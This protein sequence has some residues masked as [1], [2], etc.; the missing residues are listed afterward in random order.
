MAYDPR[1]TP[2]PSGWV[3]SR[4]PHPKGIAFGAMMP[5]S[6]KQLL[7]L[8]EPWLRWTDLQKLPGTSLVHKYI[9]SAGKRRHVGIPQRL[10]QSQSLCSNFIENKSE[11]MHP[12][13][14][15]HG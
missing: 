13:I 3:P 1:S 15:S 8:V 6:F 10:K 2:V 11:N 12:F 14:V 4:G 5:P 9:D 7:M